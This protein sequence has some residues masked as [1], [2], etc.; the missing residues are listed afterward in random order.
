MTEGVVMNS[1]SAD[2]PLQVGDTLETGSVFGNSAIWTVA[3]VVKG[4]VYKIQHESGASRYVR[5]AKDKEG[6]KYGIFVYVHKNANGRW[7]RDET[8]PAYYWASLPKRPVN[9]AGLLV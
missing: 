3:K 1:I 9:N 7:V 2:E 6:I 5:R 4:G 8:G